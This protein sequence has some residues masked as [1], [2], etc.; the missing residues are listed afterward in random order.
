MNQHQKRVLGE[1]KDQPGPFWSILWVWSFE[2]DERRG[3]KFRPANEA[4]FLS[5][6]ATTTK[7][8]KAV[9]QNAEEAMLSFLVMVAARL[10]PVP[11]RNSAKR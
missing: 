5:V 6:I 10:L 8:L 7:G 4:T 9:T 3:Q 1:K 11:L 2:Q